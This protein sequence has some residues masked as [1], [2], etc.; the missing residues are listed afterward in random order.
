MP[1]HN[2]VYEDALYRMKDM[3]D[4]GSIG[5]VTNIFVMYNIHHPESVAARYPGASPLM[6]YFML[7]PQPKIHLHGFM[8][9]MKVIRQ[10]M[11]HHAYVTL[12]LAGAGLFC[13]AVLCQFARLP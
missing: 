3:I 8:L 1:G 10:I 2:Y 9:W 4:N 12:F 7:L 5:R 13:S 11:T 6:Y